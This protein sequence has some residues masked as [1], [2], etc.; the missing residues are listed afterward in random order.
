MNKPFGYLNILII[1]LLMNFIVP[2]I[3]DRTIFSVSYI[4]ADRISK[5]TW[6]DFCEKDYS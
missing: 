2:R 4:M 6:I 5:Q 1:L 3:K